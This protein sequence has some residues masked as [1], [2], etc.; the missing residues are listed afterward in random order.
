MYALPDNPIFYQ[1]LV[2]GYLGATMSEG[3][4]DPSEAT[5]RV[6]FSKWDGF[7][8]ERVVGSKRVAGMLK[9]TNGDTFD[10]I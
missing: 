4:I 5:V 2:S 3:T 7:R 6:M 1:E 9:D 10:F 8:L